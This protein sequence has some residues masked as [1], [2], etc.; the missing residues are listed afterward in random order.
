M[1]KFSKNIINLS[2]CIVLCLTLSFSGCAS[3]DDKILSESSKLIGEGKYKEARQILYSDKSINKCFDFAKDYPRSADI[4]TFDCAKVYLNLAL[5]TNYEGEGK[6]K[7]AGEYYLDR[8]DNLAIN[9]G[10]KV[11]DWDRYGNLLD[12]LYL[13]IFKISSHRQ[14]IFLCDHI[15]RKAGG[16]DKRKIE[17]LKSTGI[18]YYCLGMYHKKAYEDSMNLDIRLGADA[19]IAF[20]GYDMNGHVPSIVYSESVNPQI[21]LNDEIRIK[22]IE[23]KKNLMKMMLLYKDG[24]EMF[25]G[26][27]PALEKDKEIISPA[28]TSRKDDNPSII[29][30]TEPITVTVSGQGKDKESALTDAFRRAVEGVAGVYVYSE[31]EVSK[32]KVVKDD[33]IIHSRGYVRDYHIFSEKKMDDGTILLNTTA[34]VDNKGISSIIRKASITT[35]DMVI[36][37]I[38]IITQK[39][40]RLKK[41]VELLKTVTSK[42]VSEKYFFNYMGYTVKD[43]GIDNVE[44]TYQ[45]QISLNPAYWGLYREV[46][47][48]INEYSLKDTVLAGAL[49]K[50]SDLR[51]NFS[52]SFLDDI[53][54]TLASDWSS[55]Y[56]SGDGPIYYFYN[57]PVVR[58]N[59][60]LQPYLEKPFSCKINILPGGNFTVEI[61]QNL[62]KMEGWTKN[63][64]LLN[65]DNKQVIIDVPFCIANMKEINKFKIIVE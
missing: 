54:K 44:G 30:D 9:L 14:D 39:Q 26:K 21:K 4:P 28:R 64:L 56:R 35:T 8:A 12:G 36:G 27:S 37:D 50:N 60:H 24:L 45:I 10:I 23:E 43:V 32:Y 3:I 31:T 1:E 34:T 49:F 17:N 47:E 40:E 52:M 16:V 29:T 5:I 11:G 59:K 62:I 7:E 6:D 48:Q 55:E 63:K 57:K 46:L 38:A 53:R 22:M 18:Y 65:D 61:Y 51:G 25:L 2:L 13:E 58:I 33:I 42:K 20:S 15:I 19:I 41:S